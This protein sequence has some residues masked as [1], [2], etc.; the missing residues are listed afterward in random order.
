MA[1]PTTITLN[2]G[3]PAADLVFANSI[4]LSGSKRVYYAPSPQG[5]LQGRPTLTVSHETTKAGVVRTNLQV[6]IPVW[7]VSKLAYDGFI[8]SDLTLTRPLTAPTAQADKALECV[9]E[10]DSLRANLVAAEV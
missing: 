1:L 3:S 9:Q 10:T 5:D 4:Q 6:I 2:V 7:N 8:K